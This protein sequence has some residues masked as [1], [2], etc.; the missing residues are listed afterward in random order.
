MGWSECHSLLS[1]AS[2]CSHLPARQRPSAHSTCY[3]T[4]RVTTQYLVNNNVP[5]IEWPA[6]SRDISPTEHLWGCLGQRI[7][8]RPQMNKLRDLEN[9]LHWSGMLSP[10][11]LFTDLSDDENT[12]YASSCCTWWSYALLIFQCDPTC[13]SRVDD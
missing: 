3:N 7:S 12:L 5:L 10:R 4:A 11:T 13:F 9:A 6:L 2:G 8:R 1:R